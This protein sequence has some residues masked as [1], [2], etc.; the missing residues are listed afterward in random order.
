MKSMSMDGATCIDKICF[1]KKNLTVQVI[2]K[3]NVFI[4]LCGL[5]YSGSDPKLG[6]PPRPHDKQKQC[7]LQ[8]DCAVM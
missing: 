7:L 4:A 5:W 1:R 6:A 2:N 8:L 3:N